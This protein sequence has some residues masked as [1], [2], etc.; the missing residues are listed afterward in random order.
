MSDALDADLRGLRDALAKRLPEWDRTPG[1]RFSP[2]ELGALLRARLP[3][4]GVKARSGRV[5]AYGM[6]EDR[7]AA[8]APLLDVVAEH[9]WSVESDVAVLPTP[10]LIVA[11]RAGPLPWDALLTTHLLARHTA[12]GARPRFLVESRLAAQPFVFPALVR[13]GAL[14]ACRANAE[15][16]L[17]EGHSVLVFPETGGR[18]RAGRPRSFGG[19][20]LV[21]TARAAGCPVVPA[22]ICRGALRLGPTRW[23]LWIGTPRDVSPRKR[24]RAGG[25]DAKRVT[26]ALRASVCGLLDRA[27]AE[28]RRR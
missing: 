16:L 4:L 27:E 12:D 2:F 22:A 8:M 11:N 3:R 23:Q 5:D 14:R 15:R 6:D 26:D 19:G 20:G 7:V 28:P 9:C 13:L 25:D 10:C 18:D 1:A 24:G 21:H 17:R